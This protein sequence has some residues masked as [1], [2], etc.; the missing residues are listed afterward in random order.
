MKENALNEDALNGDAII[1]DAVNEDW[2]KGCEICTAGLCA[3]MDKYIDKHNMT[4]RMAAKYLAGSAEKVI[5]FPLYNPDQIR[6]QYRYHKGKN[7]DKVDGIH[8]PKADVTAKAKQDGKTVPRIFSTVGIPGPKSPGD[9]IKL[10][11]HAEALAE[12]LQHW[13]DGRMKPESEQE[14]A[15]AQSVKGAAT[16]IIGAYAKLGIRVETSN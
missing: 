12:G 13:A 14:I 9:F 5:G 3:T 15:A 1:E 16:Q 4:E 2:L 11:Q 8:P 7:K 6:N 10:R